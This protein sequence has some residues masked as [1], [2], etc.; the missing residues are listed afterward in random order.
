MRHSNDN[1]TRV[2]KTAHP[3][4]ST[5]KNRAPSVA[6]LGAGLMGR[7]LAVA[8]TQKEQATPYQVTLFDKDDEQGHASAA[9]LAAAMLAPLAESA[10]ASRN[11]MQ[12]GERSLELWP[13]FLQTLVEPVFFQR[14]GTVVLAYEQDSPCLL[15]FKRRLKHQSAADVTMLNRAEIG[16]LEPDLI[17][18]T[19]H[20]TSGLFLPNEGQLDN[21][22]LLRSLA[23]TIKQRD[24]AWF[25]NTSVEPHQSAGNQVWIDHQPKSFDWVID[26][27]GLGAKMAIQADAE[28]NTNNFS[29]LRGV[30]GE[31]IRVHAPEVKISRPVRLMHPRYP[32]YI[33][34]K[35]NQQF[36]IGAT[37]I[38]SEDLRQPTVRSVLELLSSCFS[39]HRGFAEA[40]VLEMSA[41]LRPAL[42]DNEP[43]IWHQDRHIKINGL[44]RHG[45]LLAPALMEQCLTIINQAEVSEQGHNQNR[46]ACSNSYQIQTGNTAPL[47]EPAYE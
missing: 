35:P 23:I 3:T 28:N 8:L 19:R 27:R 33:A 32:I 16:A 9:H 43:K 14:Q 21:R 15:D 20:F 30:R 7:M 36:V 1:S 25:T 37:Q 29:Q 26:C 42:P 46:Q 6:I 10:E 24:I 12:L 18:Q 17:N 44:F 5:V 34:P 11:I 2:K 41:G 22:G 45:Y 47:E 31:V 38:E 39:V 40:E 4:S 13:Q